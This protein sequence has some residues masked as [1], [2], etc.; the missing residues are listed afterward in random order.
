MPTTILHF[1]FSFFFFGVWKDFE[2]TAKTEKPFWKQILLWVGESLWQLLFFYV[3]ICAT[4]KNYSDWHSKNFA[5]LKLSSLWGKR[6]SGCPCACCGNWQVDFQ[7]SIM[8]LL[9][10]LFKRKPPSYFLVNQPERTA[11]DLSKLYKDTEGFLPYISDK[12]EYYF[13][14]VICS[15]WSFFHIWYPCALST[16]LPVVSKL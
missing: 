11:T 12:K 15:L 3:H 1:L 14:I 2:T 8:F 16:I 4:A 13:C 5:L 9:D 7:G 6:H 10:N